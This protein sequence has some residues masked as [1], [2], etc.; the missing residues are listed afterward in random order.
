MNSVPRKLT[1]GLGLALVAAACGDDVTVQETP[2][3]TPVVRSVIVTPGSATVAPGGSF[4]FGAAVNADA[5]ITDRTVNWST[6][7]QN[8]AG[9]DQDG[10]ATAVASLTAGGVASICAAANADQTVKSCAQLTVTPAAPPATVQIAAITVTCQPLTQSNPAFAACGL[11][12]AVSTSNVFGQMDVAVDI[13][14]PAGTAS[15]ITGVRLEILNSATGTVEDSY[16][17]SLSGDFLASD[18]NAIGFQTGQSN[19]V[20][21]EVQTAKYD[22]S[23]AGGTAK[24]FHPNG[25]KRVRVTL[26]GGSGAT[27]TA[28]TPLTFRNANGFHM[29]FTTNL[30]SGNNE[31]GAA[32]SQVAANGL[33]WK[34]GTDLAV[35][36]IPVSYTGQAVVA[37]GST[38]NFGIPGCDLSGVGP[39]AVAA[40]LSGGILT[41]TIN[42]TNGSGATLGDL[43]QYTTSAACAPAGETPFATAIDA[44]NNPFINVPLAAVNP[45][46]L[47]PGFPGNI[48]NGLANAVN[49]ALA[50]IPSIR[51]DNGAPTAPTITNIPNGRG[52]GTPQSWFNTEVVL[53]GLNTGATSNGTVCN[54]TSA[55]APCAGGGTPAPADAGIGGTVTLRAYICASGSTAT[56]C[57]GAASP[58][59]AGVADVT[60]EAETLLVTTRAFVVAA[61]DLFLNRSLS[62]GPLGIGVDKT[63]PTNANNGSPADLALIDVVAAEVLSAGFADVLSGFTAAGAVQHSLI[64]VVGG[65]GGLVRANVVGSGSISATPF[66]TAA[67]SGTP[68]GTG[69]FVNTPAAAAYAPAPTVITTTAIAVPAGP[70]YFIYQARARDQAG[71]LSPMFVRRLYVNASDIPLLTGLNSAS[72]YTGGLAASFPATAAAAVEVIAGELRLAYPNLAGTTGT[73]IIYSRPTPTVD[74]AFDDNMPFPASVPFLVSAFIRGVQGVTGA[75]APDGATFATVKPTGVRGRAY[76]PWGNGLALFSAGN[77]T[78]ATLV[79]ASGVSADFTAPILAAQI[80]GNTDYSA[81]PAATLIASWLTSTGVS[82]PPAT[83][84]DNGATFTCSLTATARGPAGTFVNPF[85]GGLAVLESF[86]DGAAAPTGDWRIISGPGAVSLGAPSAANPAGV[87]VTV[88]PNFVAPFPTLDNGVNRDFTWTITITR[89]DAAAV[90]PNT[91]VKHYRIVGLN[92]GFDGLATLPISFNF[93]TGA[94]LP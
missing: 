47:G 59:G 55:V 30:V 80:A 81:A 62:N 35:Q 67:A 54:G 39:R 9:V 4:T 38:V 52:P 58:P 89:L 12:Q 13:Q 15:G 29:G 83:C 82:V 31:N 77:S 25:P 50:T 70:A 36:A 56:T 53:N 2:Q 40:T 42:Y 90:A 26:I 8:V 37:A 60:G 22:L 57:A 24:V 27:A 66:A 75:G 92:A 65:A 49:P 85:A 86:D 28:E 6:S 41:G 63:A 11:Q 32:I 10:K 74:P 72:V 16:T 73:D 88:T 76:N 19:R 87:T 34:G 94:I 93:D 14:R 46:T 5:G 18:E 17:Q 45:I 21:F 43:D 23:G 91:T 44:T 3:P 1:V 71:N 79:G 7:D 20:T 33:V 84:T 51:L 69:T 64:S 61:F 78:P 68:A 48:L